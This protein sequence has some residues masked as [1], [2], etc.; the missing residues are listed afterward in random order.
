[1]QWNIRRLD[2]DLGADFFELLGQFF[3]FALFDTFLEGL[4][5]AFNELL[6]WPGPTGNAAND[7][8]GLDLVATVAGAQR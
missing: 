4:W 5:N 1:M 3:G 7:L 8:N 2:F 6:S